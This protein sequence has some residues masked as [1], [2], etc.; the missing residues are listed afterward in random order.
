MVRGSSRLQP[1]TPFLAGFSSRLLSQL[2]VWCYS[3]VRKRRHQHG[4]CAQYLC[5]TKM[6]SPTPGSSS[7]LLSSLCFAYSS[8][9][10]HAHLQNSFSPVFL[11]RTISGL[12]RNRNHD[13]KHFPAPK[14]WALSPLWAAWCKMKTQLRRHLGGSSHSTVMGM[15]QGKPAPLPYIML[16]RSEGC[17]QS[18]CQKAWC[19]VQDIHTPCPDWKCS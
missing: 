7:H 14:F 4:Q 17:W 13:P 5:F 19:K 10:V 6:L 15:R 16:S 9:Y 12:V 8:H 2:A 1:Q 18:E 3:S 11:C